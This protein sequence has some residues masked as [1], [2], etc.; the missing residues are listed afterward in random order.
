MI[1]S[2]TTRTRASNPAYRRIECGLSPFD[3]VA[4]W[5]GSSPAFVDVDNDGNM[6]LVIG[7]HSPGDFKV[8]YDPSFCASCNN[9]GVCVY[10]SGAFTCD[11]NLDSFAGTYCHKCAP[12]YS[13]SK[14]EPSYRGIQLP[15]PCTSCERG[16]WNSETSGASCKAC[17]AGFFQA[18]VS[19]TSNCTKCLPGQSTSAS[20]GSSKCDLCA[21]GMFTN[22]SGAPEC[23]PCLEGKKQ[24]DKNQS[25]C[26]EC[27][28]GQ[29]QDSE[30]Q[31]SCL[32]CV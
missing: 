18:N 4:L 27:D 17:A 20:S 12:G 31:Q 32:R 22:V 14:F 25:G 11:C 23:S 10:S 24:P 8:M 3:G 15:T 26:L 30:A 29:Y 9:Q 7:R 6:D 28:A 19:A 13:E 2:S 5:D 21:P 16:Y 1:S